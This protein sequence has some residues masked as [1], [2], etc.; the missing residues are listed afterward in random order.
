[1]AALRAGE[2]TDKSGSRYVKPS[3][4][5][6]FLKKIS[7]RAEKGSNRRLSSQGV[8]RCLQL[9]VFFDLAIYL[10][11]DFALALTRE[12]PF[13]DPIYPQGG[14]PPRSYM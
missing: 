1:M 7:D 8:R 10:A 4:E 14:F 12:N 11:N 3:L 5:G 13:A 2:N 6:R 9:P